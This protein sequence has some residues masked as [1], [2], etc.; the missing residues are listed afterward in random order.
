MFGAA[1]CVLALV[2]A[3]VAARRSLAAG[4]QTMLIVGY[5]YGL[6]RGRVP[7]GFTHFAFDAALLGLYF[8]FLPRAVTPEIQQRS[9]AAVMWTRLLVLWPAVC[10]AY[11]PVLEGSQ[12]IA[13]QLVGLRAWTI[14]I[15]CFVLGARV[16][17]NDL[18]RLAPTL[19]LLNL[20]AL[21]IAGIEYRYGVDAVVPLNRTTE[22]IYLTKDIQSGSESFHRIPSCFVHSAAYGATMLF[23]IPFIL[24]GLEGT[25]RVRLLCIAGLAAAGIGVFL[26][27]SRSPVVL[28]SVA[29][30]CTLLSLR[31]R[32]AT[33]FGFLI[34]AAGVVYLVTHNERLQRFESLA[35]TDY[36]QT[37]IGGSV[38]QS[39]FDLLRAYPFGNGLASAFGTSIPFFMKPLVTGHVIGIENEY[40]R[41]LAE[42]G[43]IGL[44]LWVVFLGWT[45]TRKNV[46]RVAT[47]A[48]TVFGVVIAFIYWAGSVVGTGVLAGIPTTSMLLILC[49]MR[50]AAPAREAATLALRHVGTGR[51]GRVPRYSD[52]A[53]IASY[54]NP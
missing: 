30:V 10:M 23:S 35:D 24:H 28:L 16:E 41:I 54:K 36:V 9:H 39:F 13:V 21:V 8:G 40:G 27:G 4:L 38:N 18:D 42:E 25:K 17:R 47:P 15:P 52:R 20:F 53:P 34:V 49:G 43:I 12:P 50:A 32:F 7:D 31:M 5:L 6:A 29:T 2:G 22:L 1:F 44:V 48:A 33:L 46:P 37:R 51:G 45:F 11:S 19:A 14:M 3:F 26:C